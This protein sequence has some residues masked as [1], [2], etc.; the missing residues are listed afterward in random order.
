MDTRFQSSKFAASGVPFEHQL[1]GMLAQLD[2]KPVDELEL[3]LEGPCDSTTTVDYDSGDNC[4]SDL[5]PPMP[6]FDRRTNATASAPVLLQGVLSRAR[7][8]SP[9]K[10]TCGVSRRRD[11]MQTRA[12]TM[13]M[14]NLHSSRST[15]NRG[16]GYS[17]LSNNT[18]CGGNAGKN[19]M[20]SRIEEFESLL[21]DL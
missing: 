17:V 14:P 16:I 10:S 15:Y 2:V 13:S 12:M 5:P 21:E 20:R 9:N 3:E 6:Y 8:S 7:S 4:E 18:E 19:V 1:V 11:V